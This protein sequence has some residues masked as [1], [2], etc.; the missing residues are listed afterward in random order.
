MMGPVEA[1][2]LTI[3]RLEQVDPPD[4]LTDGDRLGG[5]LRALELVSFEH[6]QFQPDSVLGALLP[7]GRLGSST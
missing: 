2:R 7:V 1:A 3:D 4:G 5:V 6:A